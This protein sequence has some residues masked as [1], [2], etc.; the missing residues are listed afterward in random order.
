MCCRWG[1]WECAWPTRKPMG[2]PSCPS[3]P[4]SS[5]WPKR[6]TPTVPSRA[7]ICGGVSKIKA[8]SKAIVEKVDQEKSYGD[9]LAMEK[10]IFRD[11]VNVHDLPDIFHYWSDG[12]IRPKLE[13]FG[14]SGP[15]GMV[16]KYLGDHCASNQG[17]AVRSTSL[18]SG[19]GDREI[20][21][22]E[23]L[24]GKGHR[25]FAIQ[26]LDLKPAMLERIRAAAAG[27]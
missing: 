13:V 23:S 16:D 7:G 8:V 12:K 26:C 22:A 4:R 14:F 5:G 15:L 9:R 24:I 18:G 11:C 27:D 20:G 3:Q 17:R 21:M 25:N 19:I 1:I 10:D 2:W 6:G